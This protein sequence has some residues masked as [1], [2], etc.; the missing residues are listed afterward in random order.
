MLFTSPLFAQE[1]RATT[2][3][4][5]VGSFENYKEYGDLWYYLFNL[6]DSCWDFYRKEVPHEFLDEKIDSQLRKMEKEGRSLNDEIRSLLNEGTH[7]P[8]VNSYA[9]AYTILLKNIWKYPKNEEQYRDELKR[10]GIL[11]TELR[12][13]R[14]N[15]KKNIERKEAAKTG[16]C[17]DSNVSTLFESANM[18]DNFESRY[19][20]RVVND[21]QVRLLKII[22]ASFKDAEDIIEAALK[23]K[24]TYALNVFTELLSSRVRWKISVYESAAYV[25][26]RNKENIFKALIEKA[27]FKDWP[28]EA[29]TSAVR[30]EQDYQARRFEKIIE[31]TGGLNWKPIV[32]QAAI[33]TPENPTKGGPDVFIMLKST[34]LP[35]QRD[36][37]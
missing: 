16:E 15:L 32:F 21:C 33:N 28:P 10:L 30:I 6:F 9:D 23:V 27:M 5:P 37:Q 4:T 26:T 12:T 25:N 8:F 29:Y 18:D 19:K 11:E 24:S 1:P 7:V 3:F 20:N 36:S 14:R 2:N 22:Y 13:L 35:L 34:D 17:G 31:H